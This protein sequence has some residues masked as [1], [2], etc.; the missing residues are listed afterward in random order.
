MALRSGHER[1]RED[2]LPDLRH[3]RDAA[4]AC[5]CVLA[6]R[7]EGR[8]RPRVGVSRV[9]LPTANVVEPGG[10]DLVL[11]NPAW[12]YD[13]LIPNPENLLDN[14]ANFVIIFLQAPVL[15][16]QAL[17]PDMPQIGAGLLAVMASAFVLVAG[18]I[19]GSAYQRW[20]QIEL[21]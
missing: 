10:E 21:V 15:N 3:G 4:T 1:E 8:A 13:A 9:A 20:K 19:A 11:S 16:F 14:I 7:H 5:E 2:L 18:L 12:R 17:P 6:T